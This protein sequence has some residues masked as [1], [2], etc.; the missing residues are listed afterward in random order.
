MAGFDHTKLPS[1]RHTD[2]KKLL[3]NAL[4]ETQEQ[5]KLWC[6][7]GCHEYWNQEPSERERASETKDNPADCMGCQGWTEIFGQK[8]V[9]NKL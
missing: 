8:T 5:V 2:Y 3:H 7:N 9:L 6:N 4:I 1:N